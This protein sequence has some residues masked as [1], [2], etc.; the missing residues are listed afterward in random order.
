M[1]KALQAARDLLENVTPLRTD[2][3]RVCGGKCCRSLEGEETGMLLFPGEEEEY[4]GKDGWKLTETAAGTL[5]ICPGTCDRKERPLACRLF[6]L[7][8]V[9]REDGVKAAADQ[10]AKGVC[11]L[12]RAGIRGM[13]PDFT[14]AVREA[15]RMLAAEARQR[16]FLEE[17]TAEQDELRELR[18]KWFCRT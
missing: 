10:R 1:D 7:M 13:D 2:C 9:I 5:A 3:G 15:G 14:E 18:E 11:P 6:P 8:P 4:R 17:R 16:R 12:L